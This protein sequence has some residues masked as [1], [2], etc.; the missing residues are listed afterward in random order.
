MKSI[1]TTEKYG[2]TQVLV[3]SVKDEILNEHEILTVNKFNKNLIKIEDVIRKKKFCTIVYNISNFVPLNRF[4]RTPLNK[5]SFGELLINLIDSLNFLKENYINLDFVLMDTQY[6]MV[7]PYDKNIYFMYV[8][9]QGFKSEYTT[10]DLFKNLLFGA[11]FDSNE[12]KSFIEDYKRILNDSME[13]SLF[14][15]TSYANDLIGIDV[16]VNVTTCPSCGFKFYE[17]I[18]YCTECG[19]KIANLTSSSGTIIIDPSLLVDTEVSINGGSNRNEDKESFVK[20]ITPKREG[21]TI[22]I[23]EKE[24]EPFIINIFTREKIKI[25]SEVFRI[26]R[27]SS[28]NLSFVTNTA[29]S[30]QHAVIIKRRNR[31]Y[32]SDLGSLNGTYVDGNI[33][34]KNQE[35]EIYDETKLTFANEEF[36]FR[37]I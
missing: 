32:V 35:I 2:M 14:D 8:P 15:L 20:T 9:L 11:V 31:F 26:G 29:V 21:T 33:I 7:N 22:L 12:N 19:A 16:K 1:K 4:I 13:Y 37:F 24:K 6:V 28:N 5:K 25:D 3:Q 10:K 30:K 34:D 36:I 23:N 17:D 27:L 18:A